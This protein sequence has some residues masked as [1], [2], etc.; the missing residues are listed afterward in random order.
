MQSDFRQE[1]IKGKHLVD[2]TQ[3]VATSSMVLKRHNI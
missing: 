1:E 2:R 3:Y